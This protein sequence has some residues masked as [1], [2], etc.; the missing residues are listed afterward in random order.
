MHRPQKLLTAGGPQA[1][2][3]SVKTVAK[4]TH[5]PNGRVIN[6]QWRPIQPSPALVA[7]VLWG[8][9]PL[10]CTGSLRLDASRAL[11]R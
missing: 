3:R 9:S 2:F 11:D 8:K 1:R 6:W 5:E 4:R 7:A 10:M